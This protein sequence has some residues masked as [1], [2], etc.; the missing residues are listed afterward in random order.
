MPLFSLSSHQEETSWVSSNVK[1]HIEM[2]TPNLPRSSIVHII[3]A[4]EFVIDSIVTTRHR[5]GTAQ[6]AALT[7]V[8][9]LSAGRGHEN[10]EEGTDAEMH[11]MHV[12]RMEDG[13][14]RKKLRDLKI[15]GAEDVLLDAV[16][17]TM[18]LDFSVRIQ[19]LF[20][21]ISL[22]ETESLPGL[23]TRIRLARSISWDGMG[24]DVVGV[25]LK[26]QVSQKRACPHQ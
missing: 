23:H 19:G 8:R 14:K 24:W 26:L 13:S 4:D 7:V 21:V 10:K 2:P 1:Q 17:W 5:Q 9:L 11:G 3:I 20:I 22:P 18:L 6:A 16:S 25:Y 12:D 15:S